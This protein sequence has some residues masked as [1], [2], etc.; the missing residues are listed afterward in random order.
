MAHAGSVPRDDRPVLVTTARPN[1]RE[2]LRA[3]ERRYLVTMGI[4]VLCFIGAIVLFSADLKWEA[5]VAVA[6]SLVLPWL[7]VIAANA[8]P[9][10]VFESPELYARQRRALDSGGHA[11][12]ADDEVGDR[13][14]AGRY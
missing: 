10:P 4:R 1:P 8:G 12:S 7:A 9:K 6:G 3:R 14:D 5:A 2:E 11:R 13:E